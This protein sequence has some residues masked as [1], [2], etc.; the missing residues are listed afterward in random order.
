MALAGLGLGI[1]LW[2]G[3]GS[4]TDAL[5]LAHVGLGLGVVG[6]GVLQGLAIVLRPKP[7]HRLRRAPRPATLSPA[8]AGPGDRAASP[9]TPEAF[10]LQYDALLRPDMPDNAMTAFH[11]L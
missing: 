6:L 1:W 4:D 3:L 10:P 7:K 9:S 2:R 8:L 11:R 5:L